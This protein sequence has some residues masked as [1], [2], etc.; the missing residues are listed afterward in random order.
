MD[1]DQDGVPDDRDK[2]I[3]TPTECQ[4]VDAD[5]VGKCPCHCEGIKMGGACGNIGAGSIMF[6][7]GSSRI[8]PAM[9]SQLA[10]LAAQMQAD[11]T[12]RVVVMGNAGGSKV[13]QQRSWDRV[14]AV[15]E[16]M[17]ET[18]NIDRNRFIFQYEGS[19]S[20]NSVNYRSA[21]EG[22]EGPSNVAPP[23]PDLRR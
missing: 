7:P 8:T 12:C 17:S 9:Q 19:A 3:I 13:A 18:H 16:Y 14:N 20:E 15:I 22:E 23:H 11:P 1:T 4:P 5:G 10:N 6:A 2:Q 21:R